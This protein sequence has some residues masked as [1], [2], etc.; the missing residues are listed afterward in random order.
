[1]IINKPRFIVTA[2]VC[3]LLLTLP[4]YAEQDVDILGWKKA[5]WGMAYSEIAKSYQIGAWH[6]EKE[7]HNSWSLGMSIAS[8]N[9][10]LPSCSV[11]EK[12]KVYGHNFGVMFGFDSASPLGKLNMIDLRILTNEKYRGK[13]EVSFE[14]VYNIF[15]KKY[16]S[17][18][19]ISTGSIVDK[20]IWVKK[21]GRIMM[22]R[23]L[24]A[25]TF[26]QPVMAYGISITYIDNQYIP[27]SFR[28]TKWG[29]SI[30]QVKASEP[31]K[32][33]EQNQGSVVYKSIVSGKNVVIGY[34]FVKNKLVR[35]RYTLNEQ[36]TNKNAFIDDY[37]EFKEILTRKYGAPR[38]ENIDWRNDLYKDDKSRWGFAVSLGHL[39]YF[40]D[41]HSQSTS[42]NIT[43][44]LYGDN[45]SIKCAVEY[46]SVLLAPMEEAKK[47]R[48]ELNVF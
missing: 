33:I 42:T 16:G 35:A 14:D 43:L 29:M 40:S 46:W 25:S 44:A 3:W 27:Y 47:Q 2:V 5:K 39:F 21:S 9:P 6:T 7:K 12:L 26:P 36:H 18:D 32:P 8:N 48:Q 20:R 22:I 1:M 13:G 19:S 17:P 31:L 24:N 4:S 23:S 37:K 11:N 28:K 38:D 15:V 45:Y 34:I 10:T 30:E 41:W